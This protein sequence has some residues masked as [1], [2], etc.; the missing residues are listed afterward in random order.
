M[1]TVRHGKDHFHPNDSSLLGKISDEVEIVRTRDIAL[2]SRIIRML[3]MRIPIRSN[4]VTGYN[5]TG[6]K[7]VKYRRLLYNSLL[8]PDEK[9][10]WIPGAIFSG[11]R[12]LA[13][14]DIPVIY[15]T[16]Y[17][18]SAFLVG[19]FLSMVRGIPL[20]LDYRDAWTLYPRGFWD[21]RFQRFWESIVLLQASKVIFVTDCMRKGYIDRYP[22]INSNKFVT[23]TNGFDRDD[24]RRFETK[25]EESDKLKITYTGTFNDN[26]P[27]LD[28]DRSPYYFLHALS[29]LLKEEDI[30]ESIKVRF[31]GIFGENNKNLIKKLKLGS[32]VELTGPVSHDKSIEY[33]MESDLLLSIIFPCQQ[34]VPE[35]SGKIFE[36]I[37]ARKP[38]IAL[39]PDGDAKG[40]IVKE[41]LGVTVHPKDVDGI[42]N[43]IYKLYNDWKQNKLT[44]EVGGPASE[45]YEMNTL[46][47]KLVDIIKEVINKGA[48]KTV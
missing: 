34:I 10:Y 24:F 42:K 44:L 41:G 27:P 3:R 8:F 29:R 20:I 19:T 35:F 38:I 43:A 23:I 5:R 18:W 2:I 17:P 14:D 37:G 12:L 46:T 36:Y 6:Y 16:G 31:V 11:L 9:G 15:V 28:I 40:L 32:V 48:N 26:V 1:L 47:K 45:K 4:K 39:V 21:N 33:Q 13:K 25:S 7:I 30:S 22:W